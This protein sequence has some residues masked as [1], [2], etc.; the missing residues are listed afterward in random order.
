MSSSCTSIA[1][2]ARR[3]VEA[4]ASYDE[5]VRSAAHVAQDHE[6]LIALQIDAQRAWRAGGRAPNLRTR[7]AGAEGMRG[8]PSR[9][10]RLR[11]AAAVERADGA[12]ACSIPSSS[13]LPS[14]SASTRIRR[15]S[16][17]PPVARPD[18]GRSALVDVPRGRCAAPHVLGGPVAADAGRPGVLHTAAAR[19]PGGPL[20]LGRLRAGAARQVARRGRSGDHERRGRR[21]GA[22]RARL[23]HHRAAQPA[24][25]RRATPRAGARRRTRGDAVRRASSP[26]ADATRTSWRPRAPSSSTPRSG[27]SSSSSRC[28]ASRTCGLVVRRAC[29][30]PWAFAAR[31]PWSVSA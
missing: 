11:P 27:R 7:L 4:H 5:L 30:S 15:R 25:R 26:S 19:T 12:R 14:G 3:T 21:A 16:P 22:R 2:A 28:G 20:G 13:R 1:T 8:P 31:R 17:A 24:V 10:G 6:L 23:P 18:R 9:A 29:R